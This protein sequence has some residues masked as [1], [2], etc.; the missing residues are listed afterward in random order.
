MR[1]WDTRTQRCVRTLRGHGAEVS[2]LATS[3]Q[4]SHLGVSADRGGSLLLWQAAADAPSRAGPVLD[5]AVLALALSP[6]HASLAVAGCASGAVALLDVAAGTL[7]KRVPAHSGEVHAVAF[8]SL[9]GGGVLLATAG[10]DRAVH[11]W[12]VDASGAAATVRRTHHVPKAGAS[13]SDAQRER[14]WVALAWLPP[15]ADAGDA[16]ETLQLAGSGFGGDV[17]VWDVSPAAL[18]VSAPRKLGAPCRGACPPLKR[19]V[20]TLGCPD[21]AAGCGAHAQ[22]LFHRRRCRA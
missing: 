18:T 11:L 5:S 2:A 19:G 20:L 22:R 4:G 8:A 10:R 3:P 13:V 7:L 17:L 12:Q 1:L 21:R 9:R 16:P 15:P 6:A 14:L